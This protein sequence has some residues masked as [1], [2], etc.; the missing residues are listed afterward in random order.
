MKRLLSLGVVVLFANSAES[1]LEKKPDIKPQSPPSSQGVVQTQMSQ[2]FVAFIRPQISNA[3]GLAWNGQERSKTTSYQVSQSGGQIRVTRNPATTTNPQAD[4]VLASAINSATMGVFRLS[5]LPGPE[6]I[7]VSYSGNTLT[8]TPI[9][10]QDPFEDDE[11]D[12]E[13]DDD[14][15]DED[16]GDEE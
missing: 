4:I 6:R 1:K 8:I 5:G 15:Q 13:G 16:D 9:I 11:D 2:N 12:E 7:T 14:M 10:L 3:F